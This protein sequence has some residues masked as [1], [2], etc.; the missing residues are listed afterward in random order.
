MLHILFLFQCIC[1]MSKADPG[2]C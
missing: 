1:R 2:M